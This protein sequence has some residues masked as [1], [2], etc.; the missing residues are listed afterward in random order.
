MKDINRQTFV[1]P[2]VLY[3]K[4]SPLLQIPTKPTLIMKSR[5]K[6]Y[7][8]LLDFSSY[9]GKDKLPIS[10]SSSQYLAH[11]K[12]LKK[13]NKC[14]I[15]NNSSSYSHITIPHKPNEPRLVLK[16]VFIKTGSK[17]RIVQTRNHSQ[18]PR[19]NLP[20]NSFSNRNISN[21]KHLNNS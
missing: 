7:L 3:L 15:R 14:S 18:I 21:L 10:N 19:E 16:K 6:P 8:S 11:L 17:N 20:F 12:K 2:Q 1:Y 9:I 5:E 13:P 4:Y